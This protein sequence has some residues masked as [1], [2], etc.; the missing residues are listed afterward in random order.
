MLQKPKN[1]GRLLKNK[2]MNLNLST[3]FFFIAIIFAL[4]LGGLF[5]SIAYEPLIEEEI[6]SEMYNIVDG[7]TEEK[8]TN[9]DFD[10]SKIREYHIIHYSNGETK[11]QL[12][13]KN[14]E[15]MY[16]TFSPDYNIKNLSQADGINL[17]IFWIV[18]AIVFF[19]IGYTVTGILY[20]IYCLIVKIIK[21]FKE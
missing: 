12:H 1:K 13:G 11:I 19:F 3:R 17:I 6:V 15:E 21:F 20:L 9:I 4:L 14:L 10:T 5:L 7:I 16:I 8:R 18:F 2:W